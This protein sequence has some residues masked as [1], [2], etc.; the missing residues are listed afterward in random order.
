M[1]RRAAAIYVAFFLVIGAA[2]YS[3]IATAQTPEVQFQNPEYSVS[4][5]ETFQ[6]GQQTYNVSELSASMEEGG[7]GGGASLTRSATL[8]Y[9][10]QSAEYTETWENNTS[11]T[12]QDT[13]WTVL[14]PNDSD[15]SQFTLRQ[16]VNRTSL[17]QQDPNA[18]N[19]TVTRNG[20]EYV[21]VQNQDGNAT[22]VPAS[23]YFPAP[24]SRQVSEGDTLQYQGN[25]TNVAN[26]T[27]DGVEVT[28]T[29]A[30]TNTIDV[31]SDSNVTLNNQTYLAH[32]KNN[33]TLQLTQNFESYHAQ[34]EEIETFHTQENGLWG[35]VVLCG[36]V[37]VLLVG[38]AFLPSRY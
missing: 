23:E 31:S 20:E 5:G 11:V 28:W 8:T 33:E 9:T 30:R 32:F 1:Q 26:V 25:Q 29:A 3:L 38:L 12:V 14:V 13:N 34:E 27:Q 2:S 7:H 37:A 21:V 19:E 15:P 24:Q 18:D 10:E 35:I 22:L 17:L 36:S 16:N 4:K 6:V